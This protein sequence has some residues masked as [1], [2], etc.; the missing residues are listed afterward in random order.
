MGENLGKEKK[1]VQFV[2]FY[3]AKWLTFN[4]LVACQVL[5]LK[6]NFSRAGIYLLLSLL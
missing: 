2:S 3:L 6:W 1:E 4:R 5:L